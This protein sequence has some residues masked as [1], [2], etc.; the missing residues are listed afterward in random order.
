MHTRSQTRT[1]TPCQFIQGYKF[2]IFYPDLI[3]SSVSPSY[4]LSRDSAV[5]GTTILRFYSGAPYQDIA[6][7][8]PDRMWELN[9][10]RG[11][12]CNFDKGVL[13]LWFT[14]KRDR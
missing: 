2:N 4:K 3:D 1:H 12:K 13:Q 11:Y 14:F 5:V 6:F 7:R 9:K 8:I 10:R